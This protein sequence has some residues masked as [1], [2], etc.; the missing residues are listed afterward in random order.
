MERAKALQEI[1]NMR[2]EELYERQQAGRLSQE[3]V[4]EIRLRETHTRKNWKRHC[5]REICDRSV[6]GTFASASG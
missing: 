2:F 5:L 4:A 6:C 3:E 1:R